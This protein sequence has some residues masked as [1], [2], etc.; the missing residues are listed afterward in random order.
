MAAEDFGF[1]AG[2]VLADVSSEVSR[3]WRGVYLVYLCTARQ[4]AALRLAEG[5]LSQTS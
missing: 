1:F 3:V 5:L 4:V 2:A